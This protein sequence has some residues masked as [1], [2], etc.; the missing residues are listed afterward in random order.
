MRALL[1]SLTVVGSTFLLAPAHT[2]TPDGQTPAVE[3]VCNGYSGAAFGLCNSYCE[4]MDCDDNP[5]ASR[6]ACDR[7]AQRF[8]AATGK[9]VPCGACPSGYVEPAEHVDFRCFERGVSLPEDGVCI[10][11]R[12]ANKVLVCDATGCKATP[13]WWY[14]AALSE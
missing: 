12:D 9:A 3:V 14:V 8:K 10:D 1:L 5:R 2:S 13:C 6:T 7:L 4:A 11:P